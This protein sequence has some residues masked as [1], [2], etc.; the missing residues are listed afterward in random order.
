MKNLAVVLKAL[1]DESRLRI[2]SILLTSG[3]LCVCDIEGTLRF[4]Q[5][6]VS[7]H[8][9]Y[10]KKAGLVKD[11][12][13]GL[14]MI[15]SVAEPRDDAQG[16]LLRGIAERLKA[17]SVAQRDARV[18]ARNIRGGCCTTFAVLKPGAISVLSKR[19]QP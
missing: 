12:K 10:L 1:A 16:R 5:T 15:Y 4:T 19:S 11:R 6:K 13:L 3:E 9:A 2:Y 18:L 14:W 7:R 8:L 17:D